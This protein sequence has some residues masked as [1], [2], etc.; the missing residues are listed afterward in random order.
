MNMPQRPRQHTLEDESIRA[1]EAALPTNWVFR[2]HTPDYGT[3][4][5]VEIFDDEGRATGI[6]FNVQVKATDSQDE[7]SAHQIKLRVETC[8]YYL[9]LDMPVLLV[10]YASANNQLM[11]KWF[12][13]S[14]DRDRIDQN[15]YFTIYFTEKDAWDGLSPTSI[16]NE[17][18]IY[19]K[20]RSAS[21]TLPLPLSIQLLE[22]RILNMNQRS[23]INALERGLEVYPNLV[24]VNNIVLSSDTRPD[25]SDILRIIFSSENLLLRFGA[26]LLLQIPY[27]E[28][29]R[30]E[31]K[32]AFASDILFSIGIAL[33]RAGQYF[34]SSYFVKS[35][36]E[37]THLLSKVS[38]FIDA[39]LCLAVCGL[40]DDLIYLMG[41]CSK[42]KDMALGS[43]AWVLFIL[44]HIDSMSPEQKQNWQDAMYSILK[45]AST[46]IFDKRIRKRFRSIP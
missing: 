46:E 2:R 29:S 14:L 23:L 17:C 1:F 19:R 44:L 4:G 35:S 20:I 33:K 30:P 34:P 26:S 6:K 12:H 3:D 7:L 18:K 31:E 24:V 16:I 32:E 43:E 21:L 27:A 22:T 36:F 25:E 39:G 37:R 9:S 13:H 11:I 41:A 40:L 28:I 10:R 38:F 42:R 15:K 45:E 5:E 8:R